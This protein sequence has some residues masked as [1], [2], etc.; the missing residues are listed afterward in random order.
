MSEPQFPEPLDRDV[1][2]ALAGLTTDQRE[3]FEER[4][5]IL[6]Y[7]A[8]LPRRTAERDL[9]MTGTYGASRASVW[10]VNEAG[11][12]T[13]RPIRTLTQAE[14]ISYL[15]PASPAPSTGWAT[16]WCRF[17]RRR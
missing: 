8:G 3:A 4:A 15:R 5:A 10:P 2:E 16:A 11:R 6:E 1:A 17:S 13:W 7:D 14:I 9:F 12:I